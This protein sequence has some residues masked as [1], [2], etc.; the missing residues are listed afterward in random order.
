[1]TDMRQKH[2]VPG[3]VTLDGLQSGFTPEDVVQGPV[4]APQHDGAEARSISA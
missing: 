2:A 3:K 4:A 1:M